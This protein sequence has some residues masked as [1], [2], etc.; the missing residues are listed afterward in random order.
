VKD[1]TSGY[2]DKGK[3]FIENQKDII[4]KAVEAGKEAYDRERKG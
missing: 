3:E 2:V 1:K 4:S